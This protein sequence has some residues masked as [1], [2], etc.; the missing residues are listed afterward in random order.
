M[1]A[2]TPTRKLALAADDQAALTTLVKG[3]FGRNA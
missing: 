3:L 2:P 1:T